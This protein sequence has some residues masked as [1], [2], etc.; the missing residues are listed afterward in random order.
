MFDQ[1]PAAGGKQVPAVLD[2]GANQRQAVGPGAQ[3]DIGFEANIALFQVGVVRGHVGRV[4]HDQVE[5]SPVQRRQQVALQQFDA[6]QAES[7]T[8]IDSHRQRL[9]A[10]LGAGALPAGSFGGQGQDDAA[11][12]DTDIGDPGVVRQIQCQSPFDKVFGLGARNQ[13]G[14]IDPELAPVK[15]TRPGEVGE[16]NACS[17]LAHQRVDALDIGAF[18]PGVVVGDQPGAWS[19]QRQLGDQFGLAS[20]SQC[21]GGPGEHFFHRYRIRVFRVHGFCRCCCVG[22]RLHWFW[23]SP[24]RIRGFA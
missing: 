6:F 20:A 19:P 2:Q 21:R 11:R 16:W 17:A 7:C 3:R 12:S 24:G 4:A 14:R 23:R 18:E 10:D 15:L 1:Q 8:I 9:A 22:A 13:H 5:R